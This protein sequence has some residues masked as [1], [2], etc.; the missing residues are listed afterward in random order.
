MQ[1]GLGTSPPSSVPPS[2]NLYSFTILSFSLP[3]APRMVCTITGH[4][5]AFDFNARHINGMICSMKLSVRIA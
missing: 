4:F 5:L 1:Y 3:L 2:C